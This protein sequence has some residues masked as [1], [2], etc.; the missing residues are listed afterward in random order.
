MVASYDGRPD[1]RGNAAGHQGDAPPSGAL[2]REGLRPGRRRGR[3]RG[4]S[5]TDH[6]GHRLEANPGQQGGEG[7]AENRKAQGLPKAPIVRQHVPQQAAQ[8]AV[9]SWPPIG[10]FDPDPRMI[11]QVHVVHPGRARGHAGEAGQAAVD[12]LDHLPGCRPLALQHV[13]DQINAPARAIELVAQQHIGRAGR[14]TESAMHASYVESSPT[15]RPG[16][17]LAGRAKRWSAS[18]YEPAH[19]LPGLRTALGSKLALTRFVNAAIAASCGSN[20][21]VAARKAAGARISVA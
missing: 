9:K 4:R 20:T 6:R 1:H 19:I 13:L 5:Q 2:G 16:N 18:A 8:P 12:V 3:Q 10:L 14:G 11:D 21:S 17:R 7:L 15:R